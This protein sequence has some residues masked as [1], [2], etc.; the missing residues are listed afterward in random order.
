MKRIIFTGAPLIGST[1]IEEFH[2]LMKEVRL[3]KGEDMRGGEAEAEG[4]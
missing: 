4:W 2:F 3:C 1:L